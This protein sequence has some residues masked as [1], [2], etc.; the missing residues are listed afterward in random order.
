M[1]NEEA[2]H[3]ANDLLA[4]YGLPPHAKGFT[5]VLCAYG[6][7]VGGQVI[8]RQAAE[9]LLRQVQERPE[10]T[11]IIRGNAARN[12]DAVFVLKRAWIEG[13]ETHGQLMAEY[14]R[15]EG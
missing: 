7:P 10:A 8:T 15:K 13:D 6:V 14:V 4:E 11:V 1:N 12:E 5:G 9:D 3:I 2:Y